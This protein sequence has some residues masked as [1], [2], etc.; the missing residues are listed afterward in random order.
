MLTGALSQGAGYERYEL[1]N[2][3]AGGGYCRYNCGLW[4]GDD[5]IGVGPGAYSR[6]TAASAPGRRWEVQQIR[7]PRRWR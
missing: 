4:H 6:I 5:F 2:Y 1:S 7:S 3:A